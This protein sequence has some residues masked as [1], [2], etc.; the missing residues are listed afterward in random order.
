MSVKENVHV[1]FDATVA[2]SD[3]LRKDANIEALFTVCD[4]NEGDYTFS[5][6]FFPKNASQMAVV[7]FAVGDNLE[8]SKRQ[9]EEAAKIVLEVA[10]EEAAKGKAS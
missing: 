6:M 3:V 7:G 1:M 10:A 9:M 5:F 8:D 4:K 2:K